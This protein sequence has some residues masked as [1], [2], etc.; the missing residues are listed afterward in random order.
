MPRKEN[1]KSENS[2]RQTNSQDKTQLVEEKREQDIEKTI[3]AT[4][5]KDAEEI[6]VAEADVA[7]E[8][9]IGDV[10]LDLYEVKD[11]HK[12]G[13]MGL[14]YR[15]SHRGWNIDLAAKS[16]R[17]DWF[18]TE[19][20]KENFVRECETW[21]NLGLHPHIVSCY[22][23]RTLGGIP[24]VF[25]EYVEGGSLSEWI[26]E[27]KLYEGGHEKALERILDIAI[28]FAWG[29]DYAHEQGLIHQDVK[30]A[31]VMM[32]PDGTAKVTDFGLA[33]ARGFAGEEAEAVPGRSVLV[34]AGE[35]MTPA[36]CS[37]E[38]ANKEKLSRKTDIWSW[39]LSVLEMF[40]GEVTW[41]AGQAA[42]EVLESYVETGAEDE[43]IPGMPD[44][45]TGLLKQCFLHD[46]DS[47][48]KDMKEIITKLMG[49]YQRAIGQEYARIEPR[50]ADLLADGLNNRAVSFLDLGKQEEAEKLFGSALKS[51][52][53]H[54]ESTYNRGL[55]KWRTGKI[56]DGALEEKMRAVCTSHPGK[57]F[58][59]YLLAKINMERGDYKGVVKALEGVDEREIDQRDIVEM[60]EISKSQLANSRGLLHTLDGHQWDINSVNIDEDGRYALSGSSDYTTKLW[61]IESGKCLHTFEGHAWDVNF[62]SLNTSKGYAISG[63]KDMRLKL[64][65][66]TTGSCLRTFK[67]P[68]DED[69]RCLSADWR[70]IMTTVGTTL[71]LWEL[72]LSSFEC[73]RTF[74][75]HEDGVN[76]VSFDRDGRFA[77][78]GS[79][80]KTVK[81]W[82]LATGSCIRTF[83]GHADVVN[84]V[85]FSM[86]GRFALSGSKDKTVKLWDLAT[87]TCIRTF[88]GHK[89]ETK[90]VRL[91]SNGRYALSGSL[92][93]TLKLW[94]VANGICQNTFEGHKYGLSSVC[95]SADGRYAISGDRNG[96][97]KLWVANCDADPYRAPLMISHVLQSET[98]LSEQREYKIAMEKAQR[99]LKN[100]NPSEA[101]DYVRLARSKP[102]YNRAKDAMVT[103]RKLYVYLFRKNLNGAWESDALEG[104]VSGEG[105]VF[106]STEGKFIISDFG[107][108]Q[109]LWDWSRDRDQSVD[110]SYVLS[111]GKDQLIKYRE[112]ET[113]EERIFDTLEWHTDV[114]KSI[115]VSFDGRF[116]LSGGADNKIKLWDVVSGKC[117]RTFEGHKGSVN[118]VCFSLDGRYALS[119]SDDCTLMFWDIFSGKCLF[120]MAGSKFPVS[121][122]FLTPDCGVAF[123]GRGNG[124]KL[125]L[126]DWELEEQQPSDWDAGARPFVE[127]FLRSHSSRYE[128]MMGE[129]NKLEMDTDKST[130]FRSNYILTEED[131]QELLYLLGCVG[132]GWLRPEGVRQE[133]ERMIKELKSKFS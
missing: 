120:T 128:K 46:P 58:P 5:P 19:E 102:G 93:K 130:E 39:G 62:V 65:D 18:K 94:D 78:S 35:L 11:I 47:R 107:K 50:A 36:Y 28:Q 119:G 42:A 30:P 34:S 59:L 26:K 90:S 70:Y 105:Y 48:P 104:N 126:L 121:S 92:D 80:D 41:V 81:L 118:S 63:S 114:V 10:I 88:E 111:G 38:Q 74:E 108:S 13:G 110:G 20:Q 84:S 89:E 52:P 12:G 129:S 85:S 75:G 69:F 115:S 32:T 132:Y 23:V 4:L 14:V 9:N 103:W 67:L 79:K 127:M 124:L 37:P 44:D 56:T 61:D 77:L 40:T 57:S 96:T 100:K 133:L 71:K 82:D 101:A 1:G 25:A 117:L 125:W 7:L 87:G 86:D 45:L 91:S 68:K 60:L 27:R 15:V 131:F 122:V 113:G 6:K 22:Y 112:I 73:L 3:A 76:S 83:K 2:I 72:S 116:A 29:L 99:A 43:A 16:P 55:L 109:T 64:W 106:T 21:I 51:D 49:S 98:V 33:R 95:L 66:V 31:N 53:M 24:R 123:W 8:W 54:P 17:A 97:L